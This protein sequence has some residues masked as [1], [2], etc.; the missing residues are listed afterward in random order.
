MIEHHRTSRR[1]LVAMLWTALAATTARAAPVTFYFEGHIEHF[2]TEEVPGINVGDLFSGSFTFDSEAAKLG[3]GVYDIAVAINA[4]VN[5]LSYQSIGR[6]QGAVNITNGAIDSLA[7]NTYPG[8]IDP[9]H[10]T[11]PAIGPLTPYFLNL[12]LIDDTGQAFNS[13]TLPTALDLSTFTHSAF[14]FNWLHSYYSQVAA[15]GPLTYLSTTDPSA[16][17][18][19]NVA[20]LVLGGT[21]LAM[22]IRRRRRVPWQHGEQQARQHR[23]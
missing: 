2:Y 6:P 18:E 21:A 3:E 20:A 4:M 22:M 23:T 15:Y 1:L 12:D 9:I 8:F 10:N 7:I 5:G 13:N 17:P 11:G 14:Y 16:V 19:P